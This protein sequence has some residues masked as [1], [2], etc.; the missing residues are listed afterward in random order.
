M[1]APAV[2]STFQTISHEP[3]CTVV[4]TIHRKAIAIISTVDP[5]G[6]DNIDLGGGGD[7]DIILTWKLELKWKQVAETTRILLVEV[8]VTS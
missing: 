4:A 7:T 3:V 6:K 8:E 1:Q 5:S 2:R